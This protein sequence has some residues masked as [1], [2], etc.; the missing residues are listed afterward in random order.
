MA[1]G[2]KTALVVL[3]DAGVAVIST[4]K[5]YTEPIMKEGE[6]RQENLL[7]GLWTRSIEDSFQKGKNEY[8][9]DLIMAEAL[10]IAS[11]F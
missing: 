2:Q 11:S 7:G 6:Y 1:S 3:G 5:E 8:Q 4:V 9:K 10:L